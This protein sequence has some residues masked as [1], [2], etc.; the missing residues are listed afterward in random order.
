MPDSPERSTR[1]IV[2]SPRLALDCRNRLYPSLTTT[3]KLV[4]GPTELSKARVPGM[5]GTWREV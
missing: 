1:C 4:S 2:N 5:W 3:K